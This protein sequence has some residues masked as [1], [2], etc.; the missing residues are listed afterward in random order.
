[1]SLSSVSSPSV[2]PA[3]TYSVG[4]YSPALLYS[5]KIGPVDLNRHL[6]QIER[7]RQYNRDYYQ[8]NVKPKKEREK[9]ELDLLRARVAQ[10]E[11]QLDTSDE[12]SRY[13]RE[14][15]ALSERNNDLTMKLHRLEQELLATKQALEVTR[16]RNFELLSIKA[17]QILPSL[18]GLSLPS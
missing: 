17:D 11:L 2:A 12:V 15:V 6:E 8:K 7:K 18:E 14:I 1:M 13:K 3:P 10:L 9:Q 4:S 16:Q 5:P